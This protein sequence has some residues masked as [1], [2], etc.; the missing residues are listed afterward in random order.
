MSDPNAAIDTMLHAVASDDIEAFGWGIARLE[1]PDRDLDTYRARL[2]DIAGD[3]AGDDHMAL[4]RAVSIRAGLGG[5]VADY[6]DPLNSFLPDV[7]DRRL[8]IPISLSMVW[9][10]V[11]R[12][13][14]I[15]VEGVGL[16]GHFLVYAAGQ[17]CD[18]FHGGEAIGSDE[19]AALVAQSM[20]GEPR[21]DRRWLRPVSVP[22]MALR[23]I[24]N[25]ERTTLDRSQDRPWLVP[26]AGRVADIVTRRRAADDV[27]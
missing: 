22:E 7:L 14:G 23:V 21:L 20:G 12:R 2:D 4:R 15:E 27:N 16:P 18:P 8:G 10:A 17:L 26:C 25:L 19:A 24:R 5:N 3:V 6:Y 9:M 13:A 1:Y 11:G